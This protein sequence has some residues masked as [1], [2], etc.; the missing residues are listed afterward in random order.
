MNAFRDWNCCWGGSKAREDSP[1]RRRWKELHKLV[2]VFSQQDFKGLHAY[3]YFMT[4]PF[5]VVEGGMLV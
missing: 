1:L 3:A 4:A 2:H 5:E